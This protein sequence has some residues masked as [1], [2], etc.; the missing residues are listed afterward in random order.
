MWRSE[1]KNSDHPV[2]DSTR[3]AC[4]KKRGFSE[5]QKIFWI[6]D[7]FFRPDIYCLVVVLC[8]ELV[9]G[10]V[11]AK[12][13]EWFHSRVDFLRKF[14]E[15][16]R[17][18][19]KFS[20]FSEFFRKSMAGGCIIARWTARDVGLP[21]PC[22]VSRSHMSRSFSEWIFWKNLDIFWKKSENFLNFSEKNQKIWEI[23]K[24]TR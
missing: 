12:L 11:R 18:F 8:T 21:L 13:T 10:I 6:S 9:S 23:S 15:K 3:T 4:L 1:T 19:R 24:M 2:S 17:K 16:S 5:C 20:E 14:S 22:R 7:F